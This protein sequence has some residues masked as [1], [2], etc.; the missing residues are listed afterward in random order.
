MRLRPLAAQARAE[1]L[2]TLRQGESLLLTMGFPLMILAFFT[3]VEVIDLPGRNRVDF[4][5]PGVLALAVLSTSMVS[6]AIA[7]GFQRSY[8]VLKRLAITPLGRPALLAAKT[9]S[10]LVVEIIQ[11]AAILAL[12]LALGWR[13]DPQLAAAAGAVLMGTV[14]FAGLGLLM[15]GTLRAEVTLAA[16]NGLYL[17]LLLLGGIIVPLQELP[18]WMLTFANALPAA[19][20]ADLLRASLS[21]T[22][23]Q[24]GDW[25]VLGGWAVVSPLAAAALFRW[26]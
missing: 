9:A 22:A 13:G 12:A 4:L 21:G 8:R 19:A 2:L 25:L 3:M 5:V 20:L 17:V 16:A 6:L 7:T 26:E 24:A 18:G 1:T 23:T 15:A 11:T 10:V 14:A